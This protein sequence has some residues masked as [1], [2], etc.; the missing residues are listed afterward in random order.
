M[1]ELFEIN[2]GSMIIDEYERRFFELLKC[3]NFIKDE[4]VKIQIFLSG[5][6]S[7]YNEKI[8]YDHPKTLEEAMRRENHLYEK[9]RGRP[10][11]QKAWDDKNKGMMDERKKGFK[12]PFIRINSQA[13]QQGQIARGEHKMIDSLGKSQMHHPIKCWGCE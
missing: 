6:P 4:K 9:S 2:L 10:T 8:Q 1:K 7:F 13:Y 12:P 11:F 5:L 3:V